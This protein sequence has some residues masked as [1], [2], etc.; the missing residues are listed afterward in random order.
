MGHTFKIVSSY[1]VTHW[2][3]RMFDKII[4]VHYLL[5]TEE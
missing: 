5:F 2:T 4:E 3:V 1:C